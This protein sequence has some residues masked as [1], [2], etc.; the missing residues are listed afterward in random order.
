MKKVILALVAFILMC[1][2]IRAQENL[3]NWQAKIDSLQ[4]VLKSK[5]LAD[6]SRVITLNH[7]ALWCINDYQYAIGLKAAVDARALAKKINYP[8]GEGM[9]YRMLDV[10]HYEDGGL[11]PH[12]FLAHRVFDN[13]SQSE[14]RIM[15]PQ[16]KSPNG[17]KEGLVEALNTFSK[18]D[19]G[20][21]L[22]HIYNLLAL[23]TTEKE[24]LAYLNKAEATFLNLNLTIP[25]VYAKIR[26]IWTL[27]GS[28]NKREELKQ[29]Y[30]SLL[31][32][33]LEHLD[34]FEKAVI[35]H[36][37]GLSIA[38]DTRD[39]LKGMELLLKSLLILESLQE[40]YALI[41]LYQAIGMILRGVDLTQESLIYFEKSSLL[42]EK[43]KIVPKEAL[44]SY[45]LYMQYAFA[46][47]DNGQ[48]DKAEKILDLAVSLHVPKYFELDARGQILMA[49]GQYQKA[50]ELFYEQDA[51]N[52]KPF[53][54]KDFNFYTD[55]YIANCLAKLNRLKE[56]NIH[57][58][59]SLEKSTSR[60][61][62]SKKASYLLYENFKKLGNEDKAF[63]YVQV[64][65]E[66]LAEQVQTNMANNVSKFN[67]DKII[68]ESKE[69]QARL[70][71]EKLVQ[72]QANQNQR[73]WLFSV[74]AGLFSALI[75]LFLL[76]RNNRNKQRA[77]EL[78]NRQKVEID[79]QRSK[80]ETALTELKSIQKQLIQSE[81]MASLG[82]LTAGIAHEIQ[83]PL[84]FVN[85]FSEVTQELA[86]E[87]EEEGE[88]DNEER[89]KGLEKELIHDIKENLI[90]INHHGQR[91]SSI[92]KGMLEH[93]R[94]S[95]G[96]KEL[97]D[98]NAL[99]DEYLRLAYHGL[100]AKDKDFQAD[101][102]T[103]FDTNLPKVD[104]IPQDIG[105]VLL[106]LINN[107]FQAVQE[108]STVTEV[109]R[110]AAS[111][112]YK[113]MV[114]ITT[115]LTANDPKQIV[116]T[117]KD[118][119]P[120]IPDEIKEKIFQPFFTTKDTGKGTGLGLSLAYDIVK[121]HGG[122]L[123]VNSGLGEGSEFIIS[124]LKKS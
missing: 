25:Y 67:F 103:D 9:Y 41:R 107:A 111:E 31:K 1:S 27:F 75:F 18:L 89:D 14:P 117:I 114:S 120:G 46:L 85:N 58:I 95:S 99:A 48:Y 98:I 110:S 60:F 102:K 8:Q 71:Q 10:L 62:I 3:N 39:P 84:N 57:A 104:V 40:D 26:E 78:L 108:A 34:P 50:L 70:E 86:E 77:N 30:N 123:T 42:R 36:S 5:S 35:Y 90:R 21:I 47:N 121:A 59:N 119:G 17:R 73:W 92:V 45:S 91:A 23:N 24:S 20:E 74:A 33:S 32:T 101:F 113:P 115:K 68:S 52:D 72:E 49:R 109:S 79:L 63:K 4:T 94:T 44:N 100:R 16:K 54:F 105:R 80:A 116:I 28:P 82:E 22:G 11:W 13:L 43:L 97:T 66:I 81:K 37:T 65:T 69:E 83:N 51:M 38:Y 56:S 93:S 88:K 15:V 12:D 96:K 6:T 112:K 118:N 106:N 19:E 55:Y 124:L 53:V 2:S 61:L 7:L 87:L 76:F 122:E 64:Y 29:E